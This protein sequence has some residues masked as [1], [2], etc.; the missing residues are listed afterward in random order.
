MGKNPI[1]ITSWWDDPTVIRSDLNFKISKSYLSK[2]ARVMTESSVLSATAYFW[3]PVRYAA[4]TRAESK[5]HR[6][7]RRY[8]LSHT[9]YTL[10]H[11]I[12]NQKQGNLCSLYTSFLEVKFCMER[13]R[14]RA[15]LNGSKVNCCDYRISLYF[16]PSRSLGANRKNLFFSRLYSSR[17]LWI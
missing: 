9:E 16:F 10:Q 1:E 12:C 14:A 6:R 8:Q 4:G 5:A 13:V 11:L 15:N 7:T 17:I 2:C 3:W